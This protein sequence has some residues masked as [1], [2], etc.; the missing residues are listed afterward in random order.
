MRHGATGAIGAVI[1]LL[2][3]NGEPIALVAPLAPAP[4]APIAHLAPPD[5]SLR[6]RHPAP[7]RDAAALRLREDRRRLRLQVRLLHHPDAARA[8]P[9]PLTRIDRPRGGSARRRA[10]SRSCCSSRRTRASTASTGRA[11]RAGAAAPR[12]ESRRRPRVDPDALPLSDHHRRRR[13]GGDG[14]EREGLQVRRSAAAACLGRGAE[15]DEA[16]R[17]ARVIR[18]AARP[19]PDASAR[20]QP[21]HHLHRRVSRGDRRRLRGARRASSRRSA[22]T[23]SG[24]FTYSHEE[25]TSA[26]APGRRRQREDESVDGGIA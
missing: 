21:A 19:D 6:R 4:F 3:S 17:H 22:S 9:Q 18:E 1:P 5:L 24:V 12:P 10:A 14:R 20:R 23:T 13:A 25:G 15:A 26:F 7:A 2:R 11:R 8:L 16:A